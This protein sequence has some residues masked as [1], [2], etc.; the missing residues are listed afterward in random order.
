V[1]DN[2]GP[3]WSLA[4]IG[5]T[6]AAL[7]DHDHAAELMGAA[8]RHLQ[9][10]GIDTTR[11]AMLA[12][13]S[14][15]AVAKARAALGDEAY[16]AAHKRGAQ[17]DYHA[18]V[19][20]ALGDDAV[21]AQE[22]SS[23]HVRG[24]VY[25]SDSDAGNSAETARLTEREWDVTRLLGANAGITNRQLA[26][27]LYVSLRTVE[28]HMNHIMCKLGVGSRAQIAVWAMTHSPQVR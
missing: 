11:L 15:S 23:E 3:A 22:S 25:A 8:D 2:W 9:R 16:S 26:E 21:S 27:Q 13:L 19:A 17:L 1:G 5:W 14:Q 28:A 4:S 7:G 6:A 20:A 10:I 12:T 24:T 18:A